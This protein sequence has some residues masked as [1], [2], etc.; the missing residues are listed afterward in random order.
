LYPV[1]PETEDQLT[2]ILLDDSA[3]AK[4]LDG[5]AGTDTDVVMVVAEA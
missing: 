4:T 5:A 3:E 2:S 1:A